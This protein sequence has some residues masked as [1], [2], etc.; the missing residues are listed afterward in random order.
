VGIWVGRGVAIILGGG[1][2]GPLFGGV[3]VGLGEGVGLI[4]VVGSLL[5]SSSP[6]AVVVVSVSES[7][8]SEFPGVGAGRGVGFP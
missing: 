7:P 8:S 1:A 5:S 4:T 6:G 3:P 2:L